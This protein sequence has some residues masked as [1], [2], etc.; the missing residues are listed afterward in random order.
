MT[1]FASVPLHLHNHG[2]KP[3]LLPP[4]T[5]A[6]TQPKSDMRMKNIRKQEIAQHIIRAV[7]KAASWLH[8]SC[9]P[10]SIL[11]LQQQ[12]RKGVAISPGPQAAITR[13]SSETRRTAEGISTGCTRSNG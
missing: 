6:A 11:T 9:S 4:S 12:P 5:A 10:S 8:N 7:S 13:P 2:R 1:H 3:S